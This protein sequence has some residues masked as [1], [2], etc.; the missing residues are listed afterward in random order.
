MPNLQILLPHHRKLAT[1]QCAISVPPM[2][3]YSY[4]ESVVSVLKPITT[5]V[6]VI[7]IA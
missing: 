6:I 4:Q 7:A 1:L 5:V 2:E 3:M